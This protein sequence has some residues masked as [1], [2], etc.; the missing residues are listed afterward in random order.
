M[1]RKLSRP[2]GLSLAAAARPASRREA[3]ARAPM[4]AGLVLASFH[5]ASAEK[6]WANGTAVSDDFP[7]WTSTLIIGR[8][9]YE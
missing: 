3:E 1:L 5:I 8:E 6:E 9:M 2:S 4:I 7:P